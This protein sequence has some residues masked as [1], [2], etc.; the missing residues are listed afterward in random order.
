MLTKFTLEMIDMDMWRATSPEDKGVHVVA[1]S[2]TSAVIKARLQKHDLD[3][4]RSESGEEQ[5]NA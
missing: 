1:A 4:A 2:P 3:K 5:G